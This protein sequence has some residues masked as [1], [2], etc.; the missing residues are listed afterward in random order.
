MRPYDLILKKRN[1][2]TLSTAE[3]QHFIQG[4]VQG[5]IPDYQMAAM[6][7]AIYFRGLDAR[8]TADLTEA[9]I[10]SGDIVDLSSIHGI[11]VDKHSTGGVGDKT[12]LVLAPL[13]ASAGVPVAKMSGR[14]LG[15]TGG[16]LDK[17]EAIP[18]FQAELS[19]EDFV[20]QVN[21][22]G[23]AVV[24]QTGNLVPADKKLYA[25]RDV[26]ATV[27]SIPL[28]AS[29]VMS[30][31]I[32]AGADKI[33]LDVKVGQGAFMKK[34]EDAF[35]LAQLMVNIGAELGKET[36][37]VVTRM[38]QPLGWAVGNALEVREAINTLAGS[39]PEDLT[40]L[41]LMLGS[42]MLFLGG[43]CTSV[44]EGKRILEDCLR[45]G[46]ALQKLA[47][48]VKAQHGDPRAIQD[49]TK[50]PRAPVQVQ[51]LSRKAGYV[52]SINAEQI[53]LTA[54]FLGAGRATK[55]DPVD[56]RVGIVLRKKVGDH[57]DTDH[58]LAEVHVRNSQEAG[59]A[60]SRVQAAFR[61]AAEKP[62]TMPLILGL[63][64]DS[65]VERF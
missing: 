33:I 50:L 27:D 16:T 62:E 1:G 21:E 57:V 60:I 2:Q 43:R 34:E 55:E 7:M 56:P 64:T 53:G 44:Q 22:V 59:E 52:H 32:A 63:V 20:T 24:G 26:T 65:G 47:E 36:V 28:I 35:Q 9:M 49:P 29:S 39:G 38:D 54:M 51:V 6:A 61:I 41:C 5:E 3:I 19:I 48:M 18:G 37:A 12:T 14:G 42:H 46:R 10:Q 23:V 25:L 31:K 8:E 13:V 17:L 40:E 45:Q 30:K 11:K 4:F 58:V 15:H